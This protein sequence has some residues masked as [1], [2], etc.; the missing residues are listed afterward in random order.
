MTPSAFIPAWLNAAQLSQAEFRVYCCLAA[1]ADTKTGIAW[2]KAETIANDCLMAR[3]TVWKS[4]KGLVEKGMIQKKG[5]RF[6]DSNRYQIICP[7]G[8]NGIPI[9]ERPNRRKSDTPIGANGIPKDA[10]PIGA[11]GAP[12]IGANGIL[13]LA[14]MDSR[15]GITNKSNQ[16]RVTN[17]EEIELPFSSEKFKD[18]WEEWKQHRKESK[19][20]MTDLSTRKQLK[21]L[22]KIGEDRAIAAIDYSITKGYQ[23]IYEETGQQ[24]PKPSQPAHRQN[25]PDGYNEK[26][27]LP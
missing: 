11:N 27:E 13:P 17:T 15:E 10:P 12:P 8:A 18:A 6:A 21:A 24:S 9:E 25:K 22:S 14:Q 1:R 5:K 26:I 19:K 7:I 3:N 23:G 20:K 16:R 4:L 2:P